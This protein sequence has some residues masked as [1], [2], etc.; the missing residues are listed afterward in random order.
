[1]P[2]VI[3]D[4]TNIIWAVEDPTDGRLHVGLSG[5]PGPRLDDVL[6]FIANRDRQFSQFVM[7]KRMEEVVPE[8]KRRASRGRQTKSHDE[9]VSTTQS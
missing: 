6:D 3:T 7:K 9:E 1:M 8:I 4:Y 2:V 5:K